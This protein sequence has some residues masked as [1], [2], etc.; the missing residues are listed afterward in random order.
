MKL[1]PVGYF[2]LLPLLL[3]GCGNGKFYNVVDETFGIDF[4]VPSYEVKQ[5]ITPFEEEK[6]YWHGRTYKEK[7]KGCVWFSFSNSGFEVTFFGTALDADFIANQTDSD[8]NRPYIAVALD[9]DYEPS[10]AKAIRLT[11]VGQYSNASSREGEFTIHKHVN[12]CHGLEEG[13]H[14]VR[15][16]KRSEC[17]TSL[18]GLTLLSTDGSFLPV[19]KKETSLNIEVY[20]DSV[21]CGY[22]I[23]SNDYYEKFSTR[24]ENSMYAFPNI[25]ANILDADIS[26]VCAGG[27]GLYDS[28]YSGS[29]TPNNIAKMFSLAD[30]RWQTTE[31]HEWDNSCYVPD[32]VI[33]ALGANDGS[34]LNHKDE[35]EHASYLNLF[36]RAYLD[37][38]EKIYQTYPN[39]TV[40]ASSEIVPFG[41]A[42]PTKIEEALSQWNSLH[43]NQKAH[44]FVEDAFYQAEDRTTPGEGHP[45]IEMNKIAGKQLAD[46]IREIIAD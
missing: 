25:A 44:R 32:V 18:L 15:V 12:L 23:E 21:T 34:W 7:E 5:S 45:N 16:Y 8:E 19:Q 11:S 29:N 46:F 41:E 14:T 37:F 22:A 17:Q 27:Y 24:T 1:K 31:Y 6:L 13:V 33:I 3:S 20:G 2:V 36:K 30:F 43:P 35:S 42:I 9:G 38:L 28:Y 26:L 40:V 10:H 4:D 39:T